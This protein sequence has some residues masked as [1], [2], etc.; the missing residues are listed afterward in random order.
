[1][2]SVAARKWLYLYLA[3]SGQYCFSSLRSL[4]IRDR[5]FAGVSSLQ[6]EL[7]RTQKGR[8][9]SARPDNCC[10]ECVRW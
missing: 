1:V 8:A 9:S 2:Q 3:A 5:N 6:Q 10:V 7:E 4:F